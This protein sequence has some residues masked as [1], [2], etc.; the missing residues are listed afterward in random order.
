MDKSKSGRGLL[1]MLYIKYQG[2]SS[3]GF[4]RDDP[5]VFIQKYFKPVRPR[6]KRTETI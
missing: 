4:K 6:Y 3:S 5:K 1:D 2:S